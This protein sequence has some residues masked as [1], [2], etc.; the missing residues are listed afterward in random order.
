MPNDPN[1]QGR[2][3]RR[4][5]DDP[6]SGF[7]EITARRHSRELTGEKFEIAFDQSEIGSRLI[8]LSQRE[9]VFI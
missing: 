2:E 9:D 6:E 7:R 1:E 4:A 5:E 8:G 3:D